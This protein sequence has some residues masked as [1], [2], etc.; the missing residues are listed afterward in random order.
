[1][2]RK[3]TG[4]RSSRGT[5]RSQTSNEHDPRRRRRRHCRPGHGR[6]QLGPCQSRGDLSPERDEDGCGRFIVLVADRCSLPH[7]YRHVSDADRHRAG[8]NSP[9]GAGSSLER[10]RGDPAPPWR[11]FG[12]GRGVLGDLARPRHPNDSA[13]RGAGHQH[14]FGDGETRQRHDDACVARD[15]RGHRRRLVTRIAPVSLALTFPFNVL[16]VGMLNGKVIGRR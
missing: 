1:M 5:A 6:V 4:D 12:G 8:R 9:G 2:E 11:S 15:G 13:G 16:T 3:E 14:R 10:R 7:P